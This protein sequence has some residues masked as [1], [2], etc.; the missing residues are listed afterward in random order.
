MK[1]QGRSVLITGGTSGIGL[2]LARRLLKEGNAVGATGRDGAKLDAAKRELPQLQICKSDVTD[3]G[4][5]TDL[6]SQVLA[7]LPHLDVLVN[8]AG[9]MRNLDL[10]KPHDLI[11]VTREIDVLLRGPIQLTQQFLPHLISR[12][13]A[14]VVNVSSGVAFIPFAISPV[15]SAAKAGLHVFS[16]CLRAQLEET[17]V[18][19]VELAPP[20]TETPLFRAEFEKEMRG[21]KGMSAKALVDKAIAGIESGKSEIRPGVA[22]LMKAMSRL[23]PTFMFN[24]VT[25]M[26]RGKDAP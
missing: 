14:L 9:I 15:Y 17:G 16:Q 2:E 13:N 11:D 18:R 24:Q 22:N 20:P 6:H 21:Q 3:P 8:N 5:I 19:V 23:A 1:M 4:A 25:R 10:N 12:G 26:S 7:A